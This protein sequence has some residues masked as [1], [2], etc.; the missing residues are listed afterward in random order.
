MTLLSRLRQN[1]FSSRE[2][3]QYQKMLARPDH[4]MTAVLL[5]A[6][7]KKCADAICFGFHPNI[8][9]YVDSHEAWPIEVKPLIDTTPSP[10]SDAALDQ[11]AIPRNHSGLAG[12]PISMRING[13]LQHFD[14]LSCDIYGMIIAAF[15]SGLV[16]L[17]ASATNPQPLRYLEIGYS[18]SNEPPAPEASGKR[19]F[20]EVDLEFQNDNTFWVHIRAVREIEPSVRIS[21]T[22]Y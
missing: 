3:H 17:G 22:I 4:Q 14:N 18:P 1:R 21:Q 19:R 16:S 9:D 10:K 15:Q 8:L 12:L 5:N 20:A 2:Q 13:K 6:A 7:I 11:S